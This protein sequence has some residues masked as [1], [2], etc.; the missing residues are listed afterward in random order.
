MTD[1]VNEHLALTISDPWDFVTQNGGG[2]FDVI[3]ARVSAASKRLLVRAT[4][5]LAHEGANHV[6]FVASPRHVGADWSALSH[7]DGLLVNLTAV[8]DVHAASDDPLDMSAWRGG[9]VLIG[10]LRGQEVG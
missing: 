3:V 6:H 8:S 4:R 2:P 5:P 10:T 7:P 1:L 9:L